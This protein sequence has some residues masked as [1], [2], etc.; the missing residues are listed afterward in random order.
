MFSIIAVPILHSQQLVY[1]RDLISPHCNQHLLFSV[2]FRVSI[3]TYVKKNNFNI[4][5]QTCQVNTKEKNSFFLFLRNNLSWYS[6]RLFF[7]VCMSHIFIHAYVHAHT[8]MLLHNLNKT[9]II[10]LI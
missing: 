6:F 1:T 5:N 3:L 8:N 2:F 10:L 9:L 7:Y 4:K